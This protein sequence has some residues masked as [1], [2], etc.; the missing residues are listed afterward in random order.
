MYKYYYSEKSIFWDTPIIKYVPNPFT[1]D[2]WLNFIK[3]PE[4]TKINFLNLENCEIFIPFNIKNINYIKVENDDLKLYYFIDKIKA[5]TTSGILYNLRLDYYFSYCRHIIK[6][7][8]SSTIY[9][10]RLGQPKSNINDHIILNNFKNNIL[11]DNLVKT[12][13]LLYS[14]SYIPNALI[15]KPINNMSCALYSDNNV[16]YNL[17]VISNSKAENLIK[18][19]LYAVFLW[20]NT[21][22]PE[23]IFHCFPI[24]G[25][26]DYRFELVTSGD[27]K[28]IS[29][30]IKSPPKTLAGRYG[31]ADLF[32][33]LKM[34]Y[35]NAFIGIFRGPMVT[36]RELDNK[37]FDFYFIFPSQVAD[38]AYI[39]VSM[40]NL[41][42]NN[43]FLPFVKNNESVIDWNINYFKNP[44][45]LF[46]KIIFF[47]EE[48]FIRDV[49][50]F[51]ITTKPTFNMF[52][53]NGFCYT[54]TYINNEN[55]YKNILTNGPVMATNNSDIF[56]KQ[57][58]NRN[59][60][61]AGIMAQGFAL[62]NKASNPSNWNW[63]GVVSGAL[64]GVQGI[65]DLTF[66]NSINER[67]LT[68]TAQALNNLDYKKS[69][70][71]LKLINVLGKN[72]NENNFCSY[73]WYNE[74]SERD[75][76]KIKLLYNENGFLFNNRINL[77]GYFNTLLNNEPDRLFCS[78][79]IDWTFYI[80]QIRNILLSY[81]T[82]EFFPTFTSDII[83]KCIE[84]MSNSLIICLKNR[85]N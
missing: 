13:E 48:L 17:N 69:Q 11:N 70:D 7:L 42:A 18:Y 58:D 72:F 25:D 6:C 55:G 21:D 77:S 47:N 44:D 63:G 32:G 50:S 80:Y 4:N 14:S 15:D 33:N 46:N 30:I 75:K 84:L 59:A 62:I 79:L 51:P 71:F 52:F 74:L 83:K 82:N 23:T 81:Q 34:G 5:I 54:P 1:N 26:G 41:Q 85:I 39:F 61:N 2:S 43:F 20:K 29:N 66:K 60:L 40:T 31:I 45:K 24:V 16:K 65:A 9:L 10:K 27:R 22:S 68:N 64:G 28:K 73:M 8:D 53:N 78:I 67:N 56:N 49:F 36:M 12:E 35:E 57:I 37:D 3:L 76:E 19:G 38:S